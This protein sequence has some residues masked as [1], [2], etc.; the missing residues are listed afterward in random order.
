MCDRG[1]R[2]VNAVATP[3]MDESD[4]VLLRQSWHIDT[5]EYGKFEHKVQRQAAG[6]G[7]EGLEQG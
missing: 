1:W 6:R 2:V 7:V 4:A 3:Y 5:M